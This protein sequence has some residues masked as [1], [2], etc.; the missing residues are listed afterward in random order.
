M[1]IESYLALFLFLF[2]F[3]FVVW[4]SFWG[5]NLAL[6]IGAVIRFVCPPWA[7]RYV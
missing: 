1:G 2:F 5:L 4:L 3:C 6:G 7:V